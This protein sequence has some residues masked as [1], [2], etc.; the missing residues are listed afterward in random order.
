MLSLRT[1][2]T[3]LAVSVMIP[4]AML[5]SYL[6]QLRT[7]DVS[8][9]NENTARWVSTYVASLSDLYWS[10]RG[11]PRWRELGD[12]REGLWGYLTGGLP[13]GYEVVLVDAA[14]GEVLASTNAK[15]GSL[16]AQA[17]A[18]VIPGQIEMVRN[19]SDGLV[20]SVVVAYPDVAPWKVLVSRCLVADFWDSAARML[21]CGVAVLV[22]VSGGSYLLGAYAADRITR[23]LRSVVEAIRRAVRS[24]RLVDAHVAF[25]EGDEEARLLVDS[26][27]EMVSML[28][29]TVAELRAAKDELKQKASLL[30][31]LLDDRVQNQERERQRIASDLHDGAIQVMVGALYLLDGAAAADVDQRD[32]LGERVGQAAEAVKEA[33]CETRRIIYGLH[34]VALQSLGL[35]GAVEQELRTVSRRTAIEA[36][37]HVVGRPVRLGPEAELGLFRIVQECLDNVIKHASAKRILVSIYFGRQEV[38]VSVMDDGIGIR[39]GWKGEGTC[40][41]QGIGFASMENRAEELGGSLEVESEEGMGTTVTVRLPATRN[42]A[43]SSG[44]GGHRDQ[45]AGGG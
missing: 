35:V 4:L 2:V 34:P 26:F 20:Y 22:V 30:Q 12:W 39:G 33:I 17:S 8:R 43:S 21:A 3:I 24:G 14:S 10:S 7:H 28:E 36:N 25:Q 37:L 45:S 16:F 19:P 32:G 11:G 29:Q 40:R 31:A 9:F 15:L 44:G 23:P 5:A 6:F 18:R 27:N 42:D 38:T 41:I 13:E 1:K